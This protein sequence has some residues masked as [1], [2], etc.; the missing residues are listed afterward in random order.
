LAA[1][2]FKAFT[3]FISPEFVKFPVVVIVT[4]PLPATAPLLLLN[5]PAPTFAVKSPPEIIP[6]VS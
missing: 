2:I 1:V 6:L 3:A 5:P 4:L